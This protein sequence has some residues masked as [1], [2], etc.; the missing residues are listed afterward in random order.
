MTAY[1][2]ISAVIP[3]RED[4]AFSD[5]FLVV[6]PEDRIV[7]V[8]TTVPGQI[9]NLSAESRKNAVLSAKVKSL[10]GKMERDELGNLDLVLEEE[11]D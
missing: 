10:L 5:K 3:E 7:W 6:A 9:P 11:I 4:D 1:S 8:A 2:I